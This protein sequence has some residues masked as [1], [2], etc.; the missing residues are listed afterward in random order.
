MKRF[1]SCI[2]ALI[3]LIMPCIS[4]SSG[5]TGTVT[6]IY[7]RATGKLEMLKMDLTCGTTGAS[8]ADYTATVLNTIAE[9]AGY[10]LE[11]LYLYEVQSKFSDTPA[12]I[13][14]D[15]TITNDWT[16]DLLGTNGADML[17]SAD[18][19]AVAAGTSGTYFERPITGDITMNITGNLVNAAVIYLRAI[20]ISH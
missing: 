11:G 5:I 3:L 12:T 6:P 8:S 7:N 19:T 13:N 9:A 20:F 1:L 4:Y 16:I 18:Y 2:V 17:D 15:L 14:S 10:S